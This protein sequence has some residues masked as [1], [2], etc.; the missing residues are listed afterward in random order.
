[1]LNAK[2]LFLIIPFIFM[3][4]FFI[5]VAMSNSSRHDDLMEKLEKDKS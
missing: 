3:F 4:G 5:G 1:M 2:W